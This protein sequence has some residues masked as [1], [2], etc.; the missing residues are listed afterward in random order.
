MADATTTLISGSTSISCDRALQIARVDAESVYRDLAHYRIT[1]A[2]EPAGWQ[3]DYEPR[4][5]ELQGGGPHYVI[6]PETGAVV[7]KRYDQ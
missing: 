2:F 7:S 6:D 1:I 5:P 4:D 3:I